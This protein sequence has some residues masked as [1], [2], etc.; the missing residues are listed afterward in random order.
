MCQRRLT[1]NAAGG[2]IARE[3]RR[4]RSFVEREACWCWRGDPVGPDALV[5]FVSKGRFRVGRNW[6]FQESCLSFLGG[7]QVIKSI[8]LMA[9]TKVLLALGL[10]Q[11]FPCVG[12]HSVPLRTRRPV[13]GTGDGARSWAQVD[14]VV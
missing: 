2:R 12:R 4:G 14:R 1:G 11:A 6:M 8:E 10:A 13:G 9:V 5:I 3:V 7:W